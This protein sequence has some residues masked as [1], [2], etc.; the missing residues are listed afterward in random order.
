MGRVSHIFFD[1][2]CAPA[3]KTK[4]WTFSTTTMND[5]KNKKHQ[6]SKF[7]SGPNTFISYSKIA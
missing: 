2:C 7:Q 1:L 5:E 4:N 6:A 3:N